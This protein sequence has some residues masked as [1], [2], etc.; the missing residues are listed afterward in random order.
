YNLA[1][2][3]IGI[4]VPVASPSEKSNEAR[5]CKLHFPHAVQSLQKFPYQFTQQVRS[6]ARLGTQQGQEEGGSFAYDL[7]E[8][9]SRLLKLSQSAQQEAPAIGDY[10]QRAGV[11]HCKLNPA[12]LT[13]SAPV[14]DV[15]LFPPAFVEALSWDLAAR[16]C[17]ALTKDQRLRGETWRIAQTMRAKAEEI[18]ANNGCDHWEHPAAHLEARL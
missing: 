17:F 15:A 13:Y 7:P 11:L 14:L 18:D 6:L 12:Y 16:I 10:V 9:M 2:S 1:L 8:P 4:S 3:H 5:I